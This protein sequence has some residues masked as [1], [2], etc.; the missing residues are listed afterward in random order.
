MSIYYMFANKIRNFDG[1]THDLISRD[2][3]VVALLQLAELHPNPKLKGEFR[4][5]LS[6]SLI[7]PR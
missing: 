1:G 3:D 5:P 2:T 6:I 7:S 4:T